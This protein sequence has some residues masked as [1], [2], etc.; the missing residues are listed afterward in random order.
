MSRL[1]N[2]LKR[3]NANKILEVGCGNGWLCHRLSGLPNVEVAGIDVNETELL[4]A[5]TV[6]K[7]AKNLMFI[8]GD[9]L[10]GLPF[11]K[12]DHVILAASLQYFT[13]PSLLM[14]TL[15]RHLTDGGQIHIVDTPF[16]S[17]LS[18]PQAARRSAEYFNRHGIPEMEHHYHHHTLEAIS[19]FN[20]KVSYDPKTFLNK[21]KR[22]L[23]HASPF[24]W[25]V[26]DAA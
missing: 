5:A 16:Y 12:F 9:I 21:L 19:E 11:A 23:A 2:H 17:S 7:D 26:I 24:P 1:I 6:F 14:R 15:L 4:Q 13:D 25:I 18:M 22:K 10:R 3:R 8:Y 20:P